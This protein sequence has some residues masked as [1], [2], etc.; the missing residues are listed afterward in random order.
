MIIEIYLM[1]AVLMPSEYEPPLRV[2]P[3]GATSLQLAGQPLVMV[4]G[5]NPEICF[6]GRVVKKLQLAKESVSQIGRN[7]FRMTIFLEVRA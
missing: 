4:A 3:D 7:L 2:D 5:R 1:G 6:R